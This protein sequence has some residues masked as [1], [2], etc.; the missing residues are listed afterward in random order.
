MGDSEGGCA[1]KAVMS[2][3]TVE[4]SAMPLH[5]QRCQEGRALKTK[6][7][8]TSACL[9]TYPVL[10][11]SLYSAAYTVFHQCQTSSH[12]AKHIWVNIPD[13]TRVDFKAL[14]GDMNT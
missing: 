14:R 1:L 3:F 5:D 13:V 12:F 2:L 10:H 8:G 6:I 4:V 9:N 7:T 11:E